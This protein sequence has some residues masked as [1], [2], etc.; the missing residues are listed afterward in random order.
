MPVASRSR[1]V[2]CDVVPCDGRISVAYFREVAI[3]VIAAEHR[4]FASGS[5]L[6]ASKVLAVASLK[7]EV[8]ILEAAKAAHITHLDLHMIARDLYLLPTKYISDCG[9]TTKSDRNR[10]HFGKTLIIDFIERDARINKS[11]IL[12][13]SQTPSSMQ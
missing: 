13:S 8:T 7:S 5:K 9:A 11:C 10:E 4:L 6:R 12:P 1:M 2:G 3:L